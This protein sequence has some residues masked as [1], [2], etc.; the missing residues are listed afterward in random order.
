MLDG[1]PAFV[2]GRANQKAKAHANR[3]ALAKQAA[4]FDC[5]I[6]QPEE[7]QSAETMRR[8][9]WCPEAAVFLERWLLRMHKLCPVCQE[10]RLPKDGC[11]CPDH[12]FLCWEC[13]QQLIGAASAPGAFTRQ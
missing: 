4:G 12:H 6:S 11:E 13:F 10:L 5:V 8:I 3:L 7:G 9:Y 1:C 2:Q